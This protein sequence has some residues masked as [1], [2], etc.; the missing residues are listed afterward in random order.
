MRRVDRTVSTAPCRPHRAGPAGRFVPMAPTGCRTPDPLAP[1]AR[2]RGTRWRHRH[3]RGRPRGSVGR[4][5]LRAAA[6]GGA[7]TRS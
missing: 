2:H 3:V 4:R 1:S 6:W 5:G 7:L